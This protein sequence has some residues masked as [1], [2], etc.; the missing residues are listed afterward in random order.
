MSMF[1][2][3]SVFVGCGEAGR[4]R[5]EQG[6]EERVSQGTMVSDQKPE[7]EK[8]FSLDR[9]DS[10][11]STA[12]LVVATGDFSDPDFLSQAVRVAE[13]ASENCILVGVFSGSGDEEKFDQL[14]GGFGTVVLVNSSAVS[15]ANDVIQEFTTDLFTAFSQ[16]ML[17]KADFGC[18]S[19]NLR[20]SGLSVS[21][22]EVGIR[23]DLDSLVRSCRADPLSG[24]DQSNGEV[25]FGYA[26]FGQGFTLDDAYE[27]E[28]SFDESVITGQATLEN[29]SALRLTLLTQV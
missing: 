21:C 6:L 22:R 15:D 26:E 29:D 23:S 3:S 1:E 19:S 8:I 17:L 25:Q 27:L 5:V 4:K 12:D 11:L 10:K 13:A 2:I 16:P 9:P 20:E 7:I 18:I 28:D 24:L 14:V